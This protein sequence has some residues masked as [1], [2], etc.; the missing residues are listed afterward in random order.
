M[1]RITAFF[2]RLGTILQNLTSSANRRT[3]RTY[4]LVAIGAL[5]VVLFIWL[6]TSWWRTEEFTDTNQVDPAYSAYIESYTGGV[7]SKETPL[8]IRFYQ[9]VV[10]SVAV[11]KA[12]DDDWF[13]FKPAVQGK[14]YWLDAQTITFIPEEPWQSGQRYQVKFELNEVL[15]VPE[16]YRDFEF[17]LLTMAQNYSLEVEGLQPVNENDYSHQQ[18]QGTILTADVAEAAAVETMLTAFQSGADTLEVVWEHASDQRTH[19]F[20]VQNIVRQDSSRAVQLSSRGA[21]IA[22][23]SKQQQTV[24]IPSLNEFVLLSHRTVEEPEQHIELRFSDPLLSNQSLEGLIQLSQQSTELRFI[25]DKNIVQV[26]P[27][28][29]LEGTTTLT[30]SEGIKNSREDRFGT[31]TELDLNFEPLKPA[32]R[33]TGQ[34]VILPSTDGMVLPFEAVNLREVDVTVMK[35]YEDNL[36]QFFQVNP[37][38]GGQELRRVGRPVAQQ[39]VPLNGAGATDLGKW[40][41]FTLDLN[42]IMSVDPGALYRVIIGFRQS[43]AVLSCLTADSTFAEQN[44][45]DEPWTEDWDDPTRGY[46]ESYSDYYYAAEFNWEDQDDPCTPSYYGS[47]RSVQKNLIASDL[48]LIAKR[49]TTVVKEGNAGN[50]EGEGSLLRVAVTDLKTTEPRAGVTVRLYDF[51]ERELA[52]QTTDDQ[53]WAEFITARTPFLVVAEDDPQRG[54]L[55]VDDGTSLSLSNF[56]V[57]GQSVPDGLKGFL[58]GDRGVWRPGDSLHLNFILEDMENALPEYHPVIFQL[59]DPRGNVVQRI[60]QTRS[61]GEIYNFSTATSEDVPT[62]IWTGEVRVGGTLFTQPLRIETIKPNRLKIELDFDRDRFTAR[63]RRP[64]AELSV[65]WLSGATARNLRAQFDLLLTPTPTSFD[66]YPTYVFD[67]PSRAFGSE[68]KE[69]FDD[70]TDSEGNAEFTADLSVDQNP[71]G[72]LNATFLGKVFEEGGNFSTDQQTFPYYAYRAF[73]GLKL[74]EGEGWNGALTTGKEHTMDMVVVDADGDPVARDELEVTLYK[75]DWQWWWDQSD[76]NLSNYVNNEYR[77]LM[78]EETVTADSGRATWNFR[79]ENQDW[80]RYY[81][82]VCDPESEHCAGTVMYLDWPEYAGGEDGKHPQGATML[83]FTA[84]RERYAV[85]ETATIRIPGAAG[86]RALVSLETGSQVLKTHWV[87]MEEGQ[88]ETTF[89]F[90]ITEA[91]APNVYVH[92]SLLQPHAQTTNDLPIRLY[93]LLNLT[94]ENPATHLQPVIAMPDKV[95]PES[96][97]SIQVA[98]AQQRPM[99]YT[100]AVVD[101]GLLDITRFATPNP[102]AHFYAREALGVKTWDLYDYV[103]GAYGGELERLLSIGGD[104]AAPLG[105]E[106]RKTNRFSPVVKFMGPFFLEEGE[107]NEH[108]FTMPNYVG[109]VRTMVVAAHQGAYGHA[110]TTTQVSQPL[111][112]LGTLPRVLSPGET[113]SLPV[114]VFAMEHTVKN[115]RVNVDTDQLL[116]VTSERSQEVYFSTIGDEVIDYHLEV[117]ESTGMG[118]VQINAAAGPIRASYEVNIPIR[119]P[120]T[121]QVKTVSKLIRPGGRWET[122]LEPFGTEGT[123][124]ATLEVSSIAPLNLGRRLSYLIHYPHGC[125]EQVISAAFPQLFL[126]SVAELSDSRQAMTE[127]HVKAA[128][129][130]LRSFR[131][132]EGAFAYWEGGNDADEWCTSYAGHFLLE[133]QQQG[134]TVPEGLLSG[135]LSYQQQRARRWGGSQQYER[136]DLTQA[137]RLYTLA[138]AGQP[139]TGAMNRMRERSRMSLAA[140]WRLAAAYALVGQTETAVQMIESQNDQVPAYRE[141]YGTYGSALRDEAMILETLTLLDRREQGLSVFRRISSALSDDDRWMSTQTTAFCLV[142]AT[143]F[144]ETLSLNNE[145]NARYQ[146]GTIEA[147]A[148]GATA[149]RSKLSVVERAVEATNGTTVSVTNQG[150]GEL[151]AQVVL[152]GIPPMDTSSAQENGLRLQVNYKGT[153]RE[154]LDPASLAQGTDF[155][156]EVTVANP[157]LQG[158]YRQLALTQVLPSGWEII[159]TRLSGTDSLYAQSTFDY[160]DI[161]D[162]RVLTYFDLAAGER[163]TFT[164]LLNAA[165]VGQFYQPAIY[166][167]AMYDNTINGRTRSGYVEVVK[168]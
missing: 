40:N 16:K 83:T 14:T 117:G 154:P 53:G 34:G 113:V 45:A 80:G 54:Y 37:L 153:D 18:L 84:D 67:D 11:N 162:D 96:T 66:Q 6:I 12:V 5:V 147:T 131:T 145:I 101:E 24:R 4:G 41:R 119:N 92:V 104:G 72:L 156:A 108:T 126:S 122:T 63:N 168:F 123:N 105:P 161:R 56:D 2:S 47:R 20:T 70:R 142:A 103:I 35:V 33:L 97:V 157:G 61:V 82:R 165:Y 38:D 3:L 78:L 99:A 64:T 150:E 81:V 25:T 90:E 27:G 151:Y 7:I 159:N 130:K 68:R 86:S 127:N 163:K 52:T 140:R 124:T 74:P 98:E 79:I 135:W 28:E 164:V 29:R 166:A 77:Q 17:P 134:Y 15:N 59:K 49:G 55:R 44:V 100:V 31:T 114:D 46:W 1:E 128:I 112:V 136:D 65:A 71:P 43:Q 75:L 149:L 94:V 36:S 23:D 139:A 21:P 42:D 132:N 102:H 48:G 133:A 137:Y 125:V 138:L 144:A 160:R 9:S 146:T 111:M 110:D 129:R 115:A 60:V 87:M 93:G 32:V 106:S 141:T 73:V 26:Y 155:M 88:P 118:H 51:Q 8:N 22:V 62:G 116:A 152:R 167:E 19:H 107:T 10:D 91:M 13:H 109:S 57:S 85:G 39:T 50:A 58:Y 76:S 121:T 143:Q 95:E 158:D 30:V 120:N 69:V 148:L 89:S